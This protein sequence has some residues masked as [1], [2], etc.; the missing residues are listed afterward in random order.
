MNRLTCDSETAERIN[1]VAFQMRTFSFLFGVKQGELILRHTDNLGKTLQH[2]VSASGGQEIAQLTIKT[3]EKLRNDETFN[4]FWER[5][6][7]QSHI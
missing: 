7:M 1:G 6:E 2:S 3:L 5:V 4:L